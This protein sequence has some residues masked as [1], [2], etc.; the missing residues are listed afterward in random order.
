MKQ[1]LFVIIG[2]C[3]NSGVMAATVWAP[4][5]P[6][7]DTNI[8]LTTYYSGSG[9]LALFEDTDQSFALNKLVLNN[10]DTVSFTATGSDYIA[11]NSAGDVTTLFDTFNF[12]LGMSLD[13]GSTW[14]A[15][16]FAIPLTGA[17]AYQIFFGDVGQTIAAD[18]RVVPLPAA[19]WLLSTAFLGLMS[20]S[21]RRSS[22]SNTSLQYAAQ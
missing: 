16:T 22:R 19:F 7:G 14:I 11:T 13:G 2:L 6:N 3:L 20:F 15:D 4:T 9:M 21:R 10:N 8:L 18:I 12:I 5:N 17:N 1:F